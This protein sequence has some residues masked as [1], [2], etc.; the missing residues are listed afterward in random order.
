MGQISR[1][2]LAVEA[3]HCYQDQNK[4]ALGG[5]YLI[6]KFKV[7]MTLPLLDTKFIVVISMM[8]T[9]LCIMLCPLA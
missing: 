4:Q 1:L 5:V 6:S 7:E 3:A 9:S 2:L 8:F